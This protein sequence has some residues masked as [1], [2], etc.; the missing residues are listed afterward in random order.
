MN[1]RYPM[2][3]FRIMNTIGGVDFGVY[4]GETSDEALDAL[5]RDAG[6]KSHADAMETIEGYDK[7]LVVKEV[8]S[9]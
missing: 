7:G 5:A 8:E 9:D 6:Y 4:E 2:K 1:R 3:K